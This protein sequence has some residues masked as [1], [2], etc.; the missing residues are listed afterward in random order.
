MSEPAA[1]VPT[2]AIILQRFAAVVGG[3]LRIDPSLVTWEARLDE[4]GAESLDLVEITLDVENEFSILMPERTILETATEEL[5]EGVLERDGL[6]TPAGKRLL[7][8]RLPGADPTAFEG[9][10]PAREARRLFLRV[11]AWVAL[12]RRI[13]ERSPRVCD[14]CG[15][16]LVQGSPGRLQCKPCGR[17]YDLPSGDDVNRDWIRQYAQEH[18]LSFPAADSPT[19]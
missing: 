10:V 6:L 2:E 18:E 16:A 9:E 19:G 3:S 17:A 13:C 11:D 7:L 14:T 5:G 1:H 8:E 4:L 12:I 15:T